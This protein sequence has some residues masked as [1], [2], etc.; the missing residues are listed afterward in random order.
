MSE[1][2][3][4]CNCQQTS[5]LRRDGR[6]RTCGS[7]AVASLAATRL[8]NGPVWQYVEAVAKTDSVFQPLYAG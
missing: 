1:P 8:V 4:C 5:M 3:Y 6:C 2:W 7:D